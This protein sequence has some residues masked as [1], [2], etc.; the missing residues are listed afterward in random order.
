MQKIV[1]NGPRPRRGYVAAMVLGTA[2]ALPGSASADTHSEATPRTINA[3]SRHCTVCWRNAHLPVSSW[4]DCT[5]EVFRR[6]LER[7]RPD[8]WASALEADGQERRE[9]MRAI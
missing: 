3:I 2:L 8:G 4:G 5:Q 1:K 7:I 9:F 6:L